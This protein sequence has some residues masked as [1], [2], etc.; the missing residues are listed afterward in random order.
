MLWLA[1][2]CSIS[3]LLPSCSTGLL[4]R[5]SWESAGMLLC[6]NSYF[7]KPN[8]LLLPCS[9]ESVGL[10]LCCSSYFSKTNSVLI[11][12][13]NLTSAPRS[14]QL[15][16]G[17]RKKIHGYQGQVLGM[18]RWSTWH[19][20]NNNVWCRL[21]VAIQWNDWPAT[22]YV[23]FNFFN[24]PTSS[25]FPTH[26]AAFLIFKHNSRIEKLMRISSFQ[27]IKQDYKPCDSSFPSTIT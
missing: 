5:C 6:C 9:R 8:S 12:N 3:G 24:N 18:Q 10:L 23:S 16:L 15:K 1:F 20:A 17:T 19:W 25:S 11:S 13:K 14:K 22:L 27:E 4:L 7:S 26:L 21:N 2:D